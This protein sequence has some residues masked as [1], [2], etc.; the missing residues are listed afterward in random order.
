MN[1]R[2]VRDDS[3]LKDFLEK[4]RDD[5][6]IGVRHISLYVAMLIHSVGIV[7]ELIKYDKKL[8]P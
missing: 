7:F 6:R 4:A 3:P 1:P 2:Y 5:H 8:A